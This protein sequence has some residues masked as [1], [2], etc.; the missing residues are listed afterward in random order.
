MDRLVGLV[1]GLLMIISVF[2]GVITGMAS[3]GDYFPPFA[4][5]GGK[6]LLVFMSGIGAAHFSILS[7]DKGRKYYLEK[8]KNPVSGQ[9][10]EEIETSHDPKERGDL[11]NENQA[12]MNI[13]TSE[14]EL[15]L[16]W[17]YARLGNHAA[18]DLH[19]ANAI[20]F[21]KNNSTEESENII[22]AKV[23][24]IKGTMELHLG[25]Y[26]EAK[27]LYMKSMNLAES[28][29][30][31]LLS[32]QILSNLGLLERRRQNPTKAIR[33][34]RE[35]EKIKSKIGDDL[36]L[37]NVKRNLATIF[38]RKGNIEA[39]DDY[40]S[41]AVELSKGLKS[42]EQIGKLYSNMSFHEIRKRVNLK[43]ARSYCER[44]LKLK[45]TGRTGE[46]LYSAYSY[47]ALG[48]I[49]ML[50][51]NLASADTHLNKSLTY[52]SNIRNIHGM[53]RSHF[54]LE[55]LYEIQGISKDAAYH[56]KMHNSLRN[57]LQ[58]GIHFSGD[59]LESIHTDDLLPR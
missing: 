27:E 26:G 9:E 35:S 58:D 15:A 44:G 41:D 39:A 51:G 33:Y 8:I 17:N 14:S 29:G 19:L 1:S 4:T 47:E 16:G 43:L 45:K 2:F 7:Y 40:F 50:E 54:F 28:A 5:L 52:R 13:K 46:Q 59:F 49:D 56:R 22:S 3:F 11:S 38:S 21:V 6:F 37:M 32:S 48:I 12:L 57:E 53:I 34:F 20:S 30:N 10:H 31:E 18:A 24:K 25:N 23:S 36:G 42:K 55:R